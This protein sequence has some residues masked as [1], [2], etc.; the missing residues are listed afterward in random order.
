[1]YIC[2]GIVG[3]HENG[4]AGKSEKFVKLLPA[5]ASKTNKNG[6]S[7]SPQKYPGTLIEDIII[8]KHLFD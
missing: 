7:R 5:F 6:E 3:C 1:M 4:V 8:N 2:I